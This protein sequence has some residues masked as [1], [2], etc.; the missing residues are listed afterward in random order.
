[1]ATSKKRS[2][3]K[4]VW[5]NFKR[6]VYVRNRSSLSKVQKPYFDLL[7]QFEFNHFN[8]PQ[9]S[10]PRSQPLLVELGF[11]DGRLLWHFAKCYPDWNCLGVDVYKPGIATLIKKC[12]KHEL[13]N[14]RIV[15]E[16]GLTVLEQL[17][18]ASI[19]KLWVFFPD[20]WPKKRHHKR[21]LVTEEFVHVAAQKLKTN[22]VIHL[23]TDWDDYASDILE[24]FT[25]HK[26]FYG[27]E[28]PRPPSRPITKYERRGMELGHTLHFFSY[29][30]LSEEIDLPHRLS[31]DNQSLSKQDDPQP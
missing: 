28:T 20:P 19:D 16:E 29:T 14:V 10:F 5:P 15:Q 6:R 26:R 2:A 12:C 30:L 31:D 9:Q 4:P 18:D 13:A 21:R 25:T 11:G 1:M 8:D 3:K 27:G 7:P 24:N 22:R 23:S 17:P